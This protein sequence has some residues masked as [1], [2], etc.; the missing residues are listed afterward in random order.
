M[1]CRKCG[2]QLPEN[3]KFCNKCGTQVSGAFAVQQQSAGSAVASNQQKPS[4]VTAVNVQHGMRTTREMYDYCIKVGFLS[5]S[6]KQSIKSFTLIEHELGENES[7]VM[8]FVAGLKSVTSLLKS[9]GKE[10]AVAITSS[11]VILAGRSRDPAELLSIP[12]N[13]IV[14]TSYSSRLSEDAITL[15]DFTIISQMHEPVFLELSGAGKSETGYFTADKMCAEVHS[16]IEG[17]RTW[18]RGESLL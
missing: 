15:A 12:I 10:Y 17:L 13:S 18:R 14:N 16:F 1:Y 5:S 7:A 8:C 11:R 2:V 4:V 3:T 6:E 9:N